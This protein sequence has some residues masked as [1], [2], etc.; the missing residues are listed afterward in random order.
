[1][2]CTERNNDTQTGFEPETPSMTELKVK[3]H[4]FKIL[5]QFRELKYYLFK[6]DD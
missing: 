3:T 5:T 6:N 2:S 1:M 4:T